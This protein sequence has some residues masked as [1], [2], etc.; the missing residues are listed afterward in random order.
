MPTENNH[1]TVENGA[2]AQKPYRTILKQEIDA[3]LA[4]LNRPP[5]GLFLSSLS[6]GL[7]LGFSVL[8]MAATLSLLGPT[9]LG[10]LGAEL[11]LAS[12]YAIGF[13]L[14]ILGRSELFT[15]HTAL[16]V[17]P[18]LDGRS[19]LRQLSRVWALVFGGNMLGAFLFAVLIWWV[20]P[21][22]HI[23]E[24]WA[25]T[26]IAERAVEHEWWAM[27]TSAILAGW[28][29]GELAWLLAAVRDTISQIACVF[30][31]T[32][33]IG[34]TQLHHVVVGSVEVFAGLLVSDTISIG[35]VLRFLVITAAGNA[36]G[37]VVFVAIIKYGH[38]SRSSE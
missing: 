7:D 29:M 32:S 12:T 35:D 19:G 1:L 6:A 31:V 15:E 10:A 8:L 24:P 25:V 2:S 34:F 36:L 23:V 18:V 13:I 4:E 30:I 14:V 38:A 9:A 16:A 28:L 11:A 5:S 37:G 21:T 27:L 20:A 22:L 26:M 33:L 3:G 17:L